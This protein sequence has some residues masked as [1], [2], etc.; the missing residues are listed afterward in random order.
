MRRHKLIWIKSLLGLWCS[1]AFNASWLHRVA[2]LAQ[3]IHGHRSAFRC[4]KA[5]NI[6]TASNKVS[7]IN[8]YDDKFTKVAYHIACS[9]LRILHQA[10]ER[11]WKP[12]THDWRLQWFR[13]STS[14][15][16][17][18][19]LVNFNDG[20]SSVSKLSD[21]LLV[22]KDSQTWPLLFTSH[23]VTVRSSW[24]QSRQYVD[25]THGLNRH[26]TRSAQECPPLIVCSKKDISFSVSVWSCGPQCSTSV[27]WYCHW[28]I[29]HVSHCSDPCILGA[30]FLQAKDAGGRY[31]T[32]SMGLIKNLKSLQG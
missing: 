29:R 19:R 28:C 27:P 16:R 11:G 24:W 14:M 25:P 4:L 17:E 30:C 8:E 31:C 26:C 9:H 15:H 20:E 3:R 18:M 10:F 13:V 1:W 23:Y 2:L 22:E 7:I 5:L 32:S 21:D 12:D 6:L